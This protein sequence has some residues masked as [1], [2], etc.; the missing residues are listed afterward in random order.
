[1]AEGIGMTKST[2][3]KSKKYDEWEVRDAMHTMLLAGE[4]VKDKKLMHHVKKHAAEHSEKMH[5]VAQRAGQLARQGRI[6]PK[7]VAKMN[8]AGTKKLD[9][10]API[11]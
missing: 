6:S 10:T 1:M 7:A 3:A 4:I 5:D 9:K 2:P 11:A 8:A